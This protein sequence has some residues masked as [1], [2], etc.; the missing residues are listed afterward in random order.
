ML[1]KAALAPL[2]ASNRRFIAAC[3]LERVVEF[4]GK[5]RSAEQ[6]PLHLFINAAS[7]QIR[8]TIDMHFRV[9]DLSAERCVW[10]IP[11]IDTVPLKLRGEKLLIRSVDNEGGVFEVASVDGGKLADIATQQLANRRVARLSIHLAT[12]DSYAGHV[13]RFDKK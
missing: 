4:D 9:Y 6:W 12:D 13:A 1:A 8:R 7:S 10:S 2:L 5:N 3:Y 11:P